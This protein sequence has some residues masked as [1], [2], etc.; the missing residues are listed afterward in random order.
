MKDNFNSSLPKD[1]GSKPI[2]PKD[3]LMARILASGIE[4]PVLSTALMIAA[5]AHHGRK[6]LLGDDYANQYLQ[7]AFDSKLDQQ[8]NDEWKIAA[9]LS[10]VVRYSNWTLADLKQIGFSPTVVKNVDNMTPRPGEAY[11]DFIERCAQCPISCEMKIKKLMNT[12]KNAASASPRLN[13]RNAVT[14]KYLKDRNSKKIA[15]SYPFK[16]YAAEY[17]PEY[18]SEEYMTQSYALK[19][20]KTEPD[21]PAVTKNKQYEIKPTDHKLKPALSKEEMID[22]ICASG[23]GSGKNRKQANMSVALLITANAMHDKKTWSGDD[24][25]NHYMHVGFHSLWGSD[26]EE[27]K[28][29]GI[30]HDLVED[31]EWTVKDL[32]KIG[33]SRRVVKAVE[34][35]TKGDDEG[36]LDAIERC[37]LKADSRRIKMRDNQHN[38]KIDRTPDRELTFKQ[39]TLYRLSFNYL[40]AVD[41]KAIPAGSSIHEYAENYCPKI[42]NS[43]KDEIKKHGGTLPKS[44]R[45]PKVI[46]PDTNGS[47]TINNGGHS[48]DTFHGGLHSDTIIGGAGAQQHTS[49]TLMSA[50]RPFEPVS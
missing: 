23:Y 40:S 49:Q 10:E 16:Q 46:T 25:A 30:L 11:D 44:E 48:N 34:G 50:A 37:S 2:V 42:Y 47:T 12:N 19:L 41:E 32:H 5:N 8:N 43:A 7:L 18:Y 26:D 38:M 17:F 20:K 45:E 33:F 24:Y 22:Y 27:F 15:R 28:I 35:M 9:V 21:V 6:T 3:I 1:Q 13:R 4:Q 31:T 36:Y 29:I 39:K 14:L